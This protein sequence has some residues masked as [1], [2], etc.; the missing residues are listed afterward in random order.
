MSDEENNK[1]NIDESEWS[2]FV[3]TLI[4]NFF[5]DYMEV[6]L[7]VVAYSMAK[8]KIFYNKRQRRSIMGEDRPRWGDILYYVSNNIFRRMFRMDKSSF[9]KLAE[10]IKNK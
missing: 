2:N 3:D 7:L 10:N 6:S 8:E 5:I 1:D 4:Y 9:N